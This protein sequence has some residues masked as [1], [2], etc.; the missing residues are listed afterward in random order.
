M[1]IQ[2]DP[3]ALST[4]GKSKAATVLYQIQLEHICRRKSLPDV[5]QLADSTQRAGWLVGPKPQLHCHRASSVGSRIQAGPQCSFILIG[6]N[7]SQHMMAKPPADSGR[8]AAHVAGIPELPVGFCFGGLLQGEGEL[9]LYFCGLLTSTR[10]SACCSM[11]LRL[12]VT[13]LPSQ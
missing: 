10:G 1:C 8:C 13:S 6:Q 12:Q 11:K 4:L 3:P 9:F 7:R 2:C 5:S